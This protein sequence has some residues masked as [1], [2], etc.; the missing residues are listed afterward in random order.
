MIAGSAPNFPYGTIDPIPEMAAMAKKRG[1]GFHVDACLGGFLMPWLK[2]AGVKGV[3]NFDFS[4]PGVTSMS[5]D[6][7]KYGYT[8]KGTSVVL[9]SS[10][11][12]RRHMYFVQPDWPGGMYASPTMAGSRSGGVVACCYAALL[13]TGK[14]GFTKKSMAI[15]DSVQMIKD[16]IRK[17]IPELYLLGDSYSSVIAFSS[18]KFDIYQI[19]DI[20]S[21]KGWNLN[22]LQ[23]PSCMHVCMTFGMTKVAALFVDDL[24][25]S[26]KFIVQNPKGVQDGFAAIYGMAA[27]FP[28][29]STIGEIGQAYLDAVLQP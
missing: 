20:M 28:D 7:H 23:K 11:D 27:N 25:E 6:T 4:V 10:E 18:N 26:V 1:I 8:T 16:R 9:F 24:K 19:N 13:S 17:E 14:D 12:L 3:T 29:R 5:A 22:S 2:K 15:H 21:K